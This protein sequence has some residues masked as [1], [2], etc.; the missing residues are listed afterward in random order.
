[1][2]TTCLKG[3]LEF[4]FF[5]CDLVHFARLQYL[6]CLYIFPCNYDKLHNYY[7]LPNDSSCGLIWVV[8]GYNHVSQIYLCHR[9]IP[10]HNNFEEKKHYKINLRCIY[11]HLS[12]E[13]LTTD[14]IVLHKKHSMFIYVLK[15]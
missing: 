6:F 15:K 1:M 14:W 11:S 8:I 5:F 13:G 9:C 2:G 12:I 3:K 4:K 10:F 7:K